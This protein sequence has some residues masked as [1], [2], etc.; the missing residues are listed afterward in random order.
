M[1]GLH[2]ADVLLADRLLPDDGQKQVTI[3]RCECGEVGCGSVS[4]VLSRRAGSVLWR[5]QTG[6]DDVA[7]SFEA[8]AY[9]REVR[10]ALADTS[11]ETPDRTAA[12]LLAPLVDR[13][14]LT[15]YHLTFCWSS[16]RI[17][18]NTFSASLLLQPGPFQLLVHL[19]WRDASP[20]E[21]AQSMAN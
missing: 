10:R 18:A 6:H 20:T 19:P 4:A 13:E 12:R 8:A 21:I 11:W 2:P 14:A 9:E 1:I 7:V 17:R 15:P 16:G 5:I 3:A